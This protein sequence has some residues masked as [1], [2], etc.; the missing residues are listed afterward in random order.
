M[1]DVSNLL[2]LFT[3]QFLYHKKCNNKMVCV[4]SFISELEAFYLRQWY[5]DRINNKVL[6]HIKK[7]LRFKPELKRNNHYSNVQ[8][9]VEIAHTP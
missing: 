2:C 8:S 3:K 1:S 4:Q 7:W 6:Q 5:T 9:H